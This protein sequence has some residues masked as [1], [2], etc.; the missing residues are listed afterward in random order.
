M[1]INVSASTRLSTDE[2]IAEEAAQWL[3][4]LEDGDAD[5]SAFATWL[6]ASPR[7]VEEFLLISA[8]WRAAD[9]IDE[10]HA[11]EIDRLVAQA[12]DN[13]KRLDDEAI[14][15]VRTLNV[16]QRMRAA[17]RSRLSAA[18][19]LLAIVS[20][21][22][23][24]LHDGAASYRTAV[25]EQRVVKLAD[26][27]IVTLNTRSHVKVRLEKEQRSV[28][29]IRGEALFDVAHDAERPF[30]V[31]AGATVVQAIG[32]QFNV[33]RTESGTT[34]SVVEG[35]VEV[36]SRA[37]DS[38]RFGGASPTV[39]TPERLTA[40]QQAQLSAE[41]AMVHQAPA[42]I[43]RVVAWRERR[44]I[45]RSEPLAAIAAEFNRYNDTQ[46]LIVGPATS[47]RRVTGVFD[48]DK[49]G[50]LVAF[51]ERDPQLSVETRGSEVVIRGP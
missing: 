44:L 24:G 39:G 43:D 32:T 29:L 47:A 38:G 6:Q 30:R 11:I 10:V 37:S 8:V 3:I 42:E 49:P 27:S 40:G 2:R 5:T 22:W 23:M 48:A 46:L 28:E 45:F 1:N 51:L 25:G 21:V 12:R 14:T 7:H 9:R 18:V 13:V 15:I 26:G 17:L 34:V 35:I 33:Y 36:S 20:A 19:A 31:L 4:D 50:A 41:G 16:Q